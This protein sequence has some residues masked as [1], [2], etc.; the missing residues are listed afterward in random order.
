MI[1]LDLAEAR[2]TWL[3]SFQDARQ[4]AEAD[5]SD[6]LAYCDA[7]GRYADFHALRHSCITMVGK[8]GVSPREHQDLARHST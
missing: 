7:E 3:Q 4:L 6:F 1:R 5:Q 2:K 8:A